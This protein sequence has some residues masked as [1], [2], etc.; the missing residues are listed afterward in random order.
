MSTAS[1]LYSSIHSQSSSADAGLNITSEMI[2]TPA[3]ATAD[4]AATEVVPAATSE[5]ATMERMNRRVETDFMAVRL[6]GGS[7]DGDDGPPLCRQHA[8]F[9]RDC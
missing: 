6:P 2:G 3:A 4:D 7:A 8:T 5:T 1:W 9:T